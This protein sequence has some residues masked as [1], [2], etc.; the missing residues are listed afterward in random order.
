LNKGILKVEKKY[1]KFSSEKEE[2][3]RNTLGT[4][5]PAA[6]AKTTPKKYSN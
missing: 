5:T 1:V 6:I 2:K 4:T 3:E